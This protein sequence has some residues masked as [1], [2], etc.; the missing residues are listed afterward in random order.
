MEVSFYLLKTKQNKKPQQKQW[1][2]VTVFSKHLIAV[3]IKCSEETDPLNRSST[4]SSQ[5]VF[6]LPKPSGYASFSYPTRPMLLI[7]PCFLSRLHTGH[8]KSTVLLV[9]V[10]IA[11]FEAWETQLGL[12]SL[13]STCSFPASVIYLLVDLPPY[14][15]RPTTPSASRKIP[16]CKNCFLWIFIPLEKRWDSYIQEHLKHCKYFCLY[17]FLTCESTHQWSFWNNN[18][19]KKIPFQKALG[20]VSW[21]YL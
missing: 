14:S 3:Y 10:H 4:F 19:N 9:I 1:H 2:G 5:M 15:G 20:I 21:L 17:D 7:L 6:F 13:W 12:Y 18:N 16:K 11:V 8:V